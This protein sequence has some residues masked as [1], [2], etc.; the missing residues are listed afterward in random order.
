MLSSVLYSLRLEG[1][2]NVIDWA[3]LFSIALL[4]SLLL[5]NPAASMCDVIGHRSPG[6][7]LSY[8]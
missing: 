1:G 6:D 2:G 8:E 3:S 7:H 4:L 5:T